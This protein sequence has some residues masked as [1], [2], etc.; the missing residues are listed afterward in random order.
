MSSTST[1]IFFCSDVILG[2][3]GSTSAA[4]KPTSEDH[5]GVHSG[6]HLPAT[7]LEGGSLWTGCIQLCHAL[8]IS[9]MEVPKNWHLW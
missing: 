8:G 7:T 6:N 2:S 4:P 3:G 9:K 1:L 5:A